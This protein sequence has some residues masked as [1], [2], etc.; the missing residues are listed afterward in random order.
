MSDLSLLSLQTYEGDVV[1]DDS[2]K[3][4]C[5]VRNKRLIES[6]FALLNQNV[7]IRD[8]F[9]SKLVNY[10]I[11]V[12]LVLCVFFIFKL[13]VQL[14]RT[15]NIVLLSRRIGIS[16][17]EKLDAQ[18]LSIFSDLIYFTPLLSNFIPKLNESFVDGVEFAKT[19]TRLIYK[20]DIESDEKKVLW[21]VT[22]DECIYSAE[23]YKGDTVY[24]VIPY[25]GSLIYYRFI[26]S[27]DGV[28]T[29]FP[30]DGD[31][32]SYDVDSESQLKNLSSYLYLSESKTYS[33]FMDSV[34]QYHVLMFGIMKYFSGD[35]NF[36]QSSIPLIHITDLLTSYIPTSNSA[37][38]VVL[39]SGM[40]IKLHPN[41]TTY[42]G[43]LSDI[44]TSSDVETQFWECID[45][46][47]FDESFSCDS[48]N[49]FYY[50]V[51]LNLRSFGSD[52]FS[53][54]V[55]ICTDDYLNMMKVSDRTSLITSLIL[56]IFTGIFISFYII[57]E[58]IFRLHIFKE[59]EKISYERTSIRIMNEYIRINTVLIP[60]LD[61]KN[62]HL[63]LENSTRNLFN[64]EYYYLIP[65]KY[66]LFTS[67]MF[68]EYYGVDMMLNY[69]HRVS[70][71][72]V[73]NGCK[74]ILVKRRAVYDMSLGEQKSCVMTILLVLNERT[75]FFKEA[76]LKS[77]LQVYLDQFPD[78]RYL[79]DSL[80]FIDSI[81]TCE[82]MGKFNAI[83]CLSL[84]Y[85]QIA[86]HAS[87]KKRYGIR[88]I[89][90]RIYF[91]D[92]INALYEFD[93]LAEC[94]YSCLAS[95]ISFQSWCIFLSVSYSL[96]KGASFERQ[97]SM[98]CLL[99]LSILSNIKHSTGT[100]QQKI[101]ISTIF[102]LSQYS[103]M[104]LEDEGLADSLLENDKRVESK[105]VDNVINPILTN[106]L[107][108]KL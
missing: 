36:I 89:L 92:Q 16:L 82:F 57:S 107:R 73:Y 62:D 34:T 21:Y 45:E 9:R 49:K 44:H 26:T 99:R 51:E 93:R 39:D 27:D 79:L 14:V 71:L 53:V 86:W 2:V 37:V 105:I 68:Q 91:Y 3:D 83:F 76:D 74:K 31:I 12:I 87:I 55:V 22:T 4:K 20:T 98:V 101:I 100:F 15:L 60:L 19:V 63:L 35:T 29:S 84:F 43:I 81:F 7:F 18:L 38:A 52:A 59:I 58:R 13:G 66:F 61:D 41:T 24:Y 5:L 50:K 69:V 42:E 75:G 46:N 54:I 72:D 95:H 25:G 88:G 32:V 64:T 30:F 70:S 48:D 8:K 97:L 1:V 47:E 103:Y 108:E 6:N 33:I 23:T 94:L 85:C 106:L 77:I 78:L 40:S 102:I 56:L 90:D 28:N 67:N 65:D 17:S 96:L 80:N 10:I 11:T 104:F